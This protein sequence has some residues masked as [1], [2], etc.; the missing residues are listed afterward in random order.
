MDVD[1]QTVGEPEPDEEM[2]ASDEDDAPGEVEERRP[3][4][5][6]TRVHS[7]NP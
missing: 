4:L 6:P 1:Q 3:L 7:V 5:V 2:M